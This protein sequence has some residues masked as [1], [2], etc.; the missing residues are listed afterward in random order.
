MTG[1]GYRAWMQAFRELLEEAER[2]GDLRA[3]V[4]ARTASHAVVA[5]TVGVTTTALQSPGLFSSSHAAD[6]LYDALLAGIAA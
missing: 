1:R 2:R 5:W 4:G 6:G 3:G